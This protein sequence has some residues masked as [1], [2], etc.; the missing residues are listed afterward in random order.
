MRFFLY[1]KHWQLFA[2]FAV[3]PL[4]VEIAYDNLTTVGDG[5]WPIRLVINSVIAF[6]A[7]AYLWTLGS[8]LYERLPEKSANLSPRWFK[9]GLIYAFVELVYLSTFA[10]FFIVEKPASP[11][12]LVPIH[13]VAMVA[14]FYAFYFIAKSLASI[15]KGEEANLNDWA[16]YFFM[17]WFYPIGIWFFQPRI[18]RYFEEATSG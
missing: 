1:M 12:Y 4:I 15:E 3:L 8:N 10:A 7:I 16:G 13:I 11:Y 5:T 2:L 9:A 18:N 17:L 14:I 6:L